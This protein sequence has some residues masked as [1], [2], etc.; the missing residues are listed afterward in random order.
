MISS[1]RLGKITV[2]TEHAMFRSYPNFSQG[3]AQFT[4]RVVR[5]WKDNYEVLSKA[6]VEAAAK[7]HLHSESL[8]Q[9]LPNLRR[10]PENKWL[11]VLPV[12]AHSTAVDGMPVWVV[13]FRWEG[14]S[15]IHKN[16]TPNLSHIRYFVVTQKTLEQIG[17]STCE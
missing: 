1:V 6:L 7:A 13:A 16:K 14:E 9:I 11:A 15:W 5:D 3:S 12:A 2:K 4:G 10:A 8:A 17:F